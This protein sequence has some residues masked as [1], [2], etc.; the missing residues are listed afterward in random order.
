MSIE[1]K[2]G[3]SLQGL[4][5]LPPPV[6]KTDTGRS[7]AA[8][9]Q[10]ST[11]APEA[12]QAAPGLASQR[13]AHR[14]RTV[15]L[16]KAGPLL[17]Q[18][19]RNET[20]QARA[21][22]AIQTHVAKAAR[23]PY[24]FK[25]EAGKAPQFRGFVN[26][27][28][29][30][31]TPEEKITQVNAAYRDYRACGLADASAR[32]I[33]V[34]IQ[35]FAGKIAPNPFANV[36]RLDDIQSRSEAYLGAALAVYP[37]L[38]TDE[39]QQALQI[40]VVARSIDLIRAITPPISP[41]DAANLIKE[42]LDKILYQQFRDQS[43]IT[44]S[45]HGIHHIVMG[46]I[47]NSMA[48]LDRC[49]DGSGH[50]V[51]TPRERLMVLQTMVDHDLGYT[52]YAAQADFGAAKDH[53]L[54]SRAYVV[55][56]TNPIFTPDEATF[57]WDSIL[58]HSYASNLNQPLD[59]L[60]SLSIKTQSLRN[61]V[62]V[63]D[64][65]GTTQDTKLPSVF[66][67][68]EIRDQLFEVGMEQLRLNSLTNEQKALQELQK[69]SPLNPQQ[70]QR[71]NQLP[72]L[73]DTQNKK[74]ASVEGPCKKKMLEAL[75]NDTSMPP[76]LK[77]RY[78][79]AITVDFNAF[80][81]GGIVPQFA[82]KL[83]S[84]HAAPD[85]RNPGKHKMAITMEVSLPEKLSHAVASNADIAIKDALVAFNKM[86]EDIA[87]GRNL[88]AEID[89]ALYVRGSAN[90]NDTRQYTTLTPLIDFTFKRSEA[91]TQY[92]QEHLDI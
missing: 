43:M 9:G 75:E 88:G 91:D 5:A 29:T 92:L 68:K 61:V 83:L 51:V 27:L 49:L 52:T 13:D 11:A 69:K 34:G 41:Q 23:C 24:A 30:G 65:M 77:A 6:G 84:A 66:R 25:T 12:A 56:H 33:K 53:P 3:T 15:T 78:Q 70:Q 86:A 73:I 38:F 87:P 39:E 50:C 19:A 2:V 90:P 44:G 62:A 89:H 54:A 21:T 14:Q 76:A 60:S 18:L 1:P 4:D 55:H 42:N 28:V 74:V 80:G 32:E 16:A 67:I 72:Q 26:G 63:V 10:T 48:V 59:F 45:D 64:A 35:T 36:I 40:E 82:G 17:E 8:P 46:N 71:F 22:Q 7:V 85:P 79:Q 47:H 37:G 81:A 31:Q 58:S 57:M 20:E